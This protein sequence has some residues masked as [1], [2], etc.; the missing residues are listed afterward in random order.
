[1]VEDHSKAS[2]VEVLIALAICESSEALEPGCE[3]VSFMACLGLRS[4]VERRYRV[5]H[6]IGDIGKGALD[7]L[8]PQTLDYCHRKPSHPGGD[9]V[10]F[11]SIP[12]IRA[13]QP[14]SA[15]HLVLQSL[16]AGHFRLSP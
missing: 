12:A 16:S 13:K 7:L 1:L 14:D 11:A 6:R 4:P 15:G 2:A 9:A 8:P 3:D 10:R 5:T